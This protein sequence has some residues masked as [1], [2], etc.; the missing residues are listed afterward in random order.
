MNPSQAIL[1]TGQAKDALACAL[2]F[3]EAD[4]QT[5]FEVDIG[6]FVCN[7]TIQQHVQEGFLHVV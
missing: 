4:L 3:L 1:S 6:A 7:K 2:S 5:T